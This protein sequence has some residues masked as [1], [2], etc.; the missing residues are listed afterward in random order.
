MLELPLPP[1]YNRFGAVQRRLARRFGVV[2][3]PKRYFANVLAGDESTL[4]GLHLSHI[5]HAKMS[6]MIWSTVM[7][8]SGMSER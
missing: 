7:R 3:V 6:R 1:L 8:D 2:L 4:D 5:G